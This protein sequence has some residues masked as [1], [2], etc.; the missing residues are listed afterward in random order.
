MVELFKKVL[1]YSILVTGGN[2]EMS[3]N[4]EQFAFKE[5]VLILR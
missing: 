4:L 1:L 2:W 3:E 5:L